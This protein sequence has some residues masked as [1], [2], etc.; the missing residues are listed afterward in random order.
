MRTGIYSH[1]NTCW[2][3]SWPLLLLQRKHVRFRY[4]TWWP[5]YIFYRCSCHDFAIWQMRW[6]CQ[7]RVTDF[8]AFL[9]SCTSPMCPLQQAVI[10]H[11]KEIE[12]PRLCSMCWWTQIHAAERVSCRTVFAFLCGRDYSQKAWFVAV[13]GPPK[14]MMFPLKRSFRIVPGYD[15]GCACHTET[16]VNDTTPRAIVHSGAALW[17]S[18]VGVEDRVAN[19]NLNNLYFVRLKHVS[20]SSN[21]VSLYKV[22][23]TWVVV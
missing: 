16:C 15:C 4:C 1:S 14:F 12:P 5:F 2:F 10:S 23:K 20:A 13:D 11:R 21:R 17:G 7:H 9:R 18:S 3:W 8:F 6:F 22:C 19:F